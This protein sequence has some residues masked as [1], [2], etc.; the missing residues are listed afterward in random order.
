M[1]RS[2][3]PEAKSLEPGSTR[4]SAVQM[5]PKQAQVATPIETVFNQMRVQKRRPGRMIGASFGSATEALW[6]NRLRSLLTALGIIIGIAA[7][8]GALT[9]TQGVTALFNSTIANLG[10]IPSMS[11]QEPPNRAES[12]KEPARFKR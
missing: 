12:P 8:I 9:L 7:V 5:V 11:Y 4:S 2:T 1:S 6:A 10:A 3:P